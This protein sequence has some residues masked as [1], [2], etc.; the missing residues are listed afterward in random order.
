M[1]K[2]RVTA[3]MPTNVEGYK[4]GDILEY[5]IEIATRLILKGYIEPY[6]E[7]L[8]MDEAK[9]DKQLRSYKRKER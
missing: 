5:P 9:Q 7:P 1:A 6:I 8:P 2:Y 4:A 3:K